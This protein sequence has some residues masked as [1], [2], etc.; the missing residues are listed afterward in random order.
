[1][2]AVLAAIAVTLVAILVAFV[3]IFVTLVAMAAVLVAVCGSV[4]PDIN[5]NNVTAP[6]SVNVV[7]SVPPSLASV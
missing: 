5:E 7:D 4:A 2:A 1:M 3:A 6:M